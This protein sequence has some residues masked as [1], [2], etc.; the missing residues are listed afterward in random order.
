MADLKLSPLGEAHKKAGL[1]KNIPNKG[2]VL[3]KGKRVDLKTATAKELELL[4]GT[5]YVI[6]S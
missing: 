1:D 6:E 4:K 2:V 3:R 5:P